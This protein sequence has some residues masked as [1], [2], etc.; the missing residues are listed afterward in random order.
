MNGFYG[1][2]EDATREAMG[3]IGLYG[4]DGRL[5]ST[6]ALSGGDKFMQEAVQVMLEKQFKKVKTLLEANKPLAHALVDALL[7]KEELFIEDIDAIV[8]RYGLTLTNDA[9]AKR[10]G[11]HVPQREN[12]LDGS[13]GTI[14]GYALPPGAPIYIEEGVG[15]AAAA[16]APM[17]V[18]Q[19]PV[20][21]APLPQA[22][23][24]T[25]QV[26]QARIGGETGDDFLPK[27]WKS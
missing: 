17:P 24:A 23:V 22:P 4:M 18:R 10:I 16:Y 12:L 27:V 8:S 6:A 13:V 15:A 11:F 14:P 9:K 1:D 25:A 20:A 19:A 2:L 21:Q 7:D 26:P 3:Y 5:F